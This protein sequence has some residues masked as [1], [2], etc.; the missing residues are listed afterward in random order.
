[1]ENGNFKKL[2]DLAQVARRRGPRLGIDIESRAFEGDKVGLKMLSV[3]N[4]V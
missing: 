1:M 2:L 3:L 4:T